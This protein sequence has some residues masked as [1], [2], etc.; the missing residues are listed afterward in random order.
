[1]RLNL[2]FCQAKDESYNEVCR[3]QE[4]RQQS[5]LARKRLEI[6]RLVRIESARSQGPQNSASIFGLGYA[7][8]GNGWTDA[9][10]RILYPK[11]RKRPRRHLK[12]ICFPQEL[13]RRVSQVPEVLVP[14]RLDLDYDRYKLRDTFVWNASDDSVPFEVFAEHLCEDYGLPQAGFVTEIQKS[15]RSQLAEH[16]PHRFPDEQDN[17]ATGR[18]HEIGE[19]YTDKKDD[20]LRIVVKIDITIGIRNLVD[21]FEWDINNSQN[22]AEQFARNL[23][24]EFGLVGEFETAIAHAIREQSQMYTKTLFLVGHAFDGR[25]VQDPDVKQLIV[26]TIFTALRPKHQMDRYAPSLYEL[27]TEQ[28]EKVERERERE[29]RRNRRQT[30]GK[31]GANLPDLGD[32]PKTYR[33]PYMNCILNPG[34][35]QNSTDLGPSRAIYGKS[36]ELEDMSDDEDRYIEGASPRFERSTRSSRSHRVGQ[37][38]L[39]PP[40]PPLQVTFVT[41]RGS[42]SNRQQQESYNATADLYTNPYNNV[43]PHQQQSRTQSSSVQSKSTHGPHMEFSTQQTRPSN[44][45]ISKQQR[46][47]SHVPPSGKASS[48]PTPSLIVKL[49]VPNLKQLIAANLGPSKGQDGEIVL[50]EP[51]MLANA[52]QLQAVFT[53]PTPSGLM[54]PH[55]EGTK[56]L[57]E[58]IQQLHEMFPQDKFEMV[59]K[60]NTER[61]EDGPIVRVRCHSCPGVLYFAS[62]FEVHLRN[63]NHRSRIEA[64]YSRV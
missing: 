27:T 52:P 14:V 12:E 50:S 20:D 53:P 25:S 31:R 59:V 16:H 29:G 54:Q 4:Q 10:P 30:R 11:E 35:D 18:A 6:E 38:P 40:P 46:P 9:K 48:S 1:M 56:Q 37:L 61:P 60:P 24:L 32:L 43:I 8:Y 5:S 13:I 62:D 3:I 57:Q 58:H 39:R 41:A 7:G 36:N 44:V 15:L 64:E 23:C 28:L 47:L 26:P 55:L 34:G 63:R 33:T 19:N 22:D 51:S 2:A 45:T 21:Q 42:P 17:S 49:K